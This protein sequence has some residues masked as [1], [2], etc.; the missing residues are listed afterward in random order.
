MK[1]DNARKFVFVTNMDEDNELGSVHC[2]EAE[3]LSEL[4][5]DAENHYKKCDDLLSVCVWDVTNNTATIY[6]YN[7]ERVVQVT[8][9][10][11]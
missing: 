9:T 7:C 4:K 5:E 11:Y 1:F 6:E 3:L 2:T 10:A 8:V